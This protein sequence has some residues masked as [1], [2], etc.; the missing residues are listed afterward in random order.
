MEQGMNQI[1]ATNKKRKHIFLFVVVFFVATIFILFGLGGGFGLVKERIDLVV[2]MYRFQKA[3]KEFSKGLEQYY[4]TFREDTYSG[5]T[6]QETLNLFIDALE[7]GDLDLATKYFAMDDN[8]SREKWEN[9][10]RETEKAGKLPFIIE[11]LKQMTPVEPAIT[12]T[13]EFVVIE[14]ESGLVEYSVEMEFN[15]YSGVWKIRAM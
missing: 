15:E 4:Q 11:I 13:Y 7:K 1:N 3:A 14:K 9:A 10:L 5:K 2:N 12:S 8:L 6:P